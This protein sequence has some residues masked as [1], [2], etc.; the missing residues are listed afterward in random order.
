MTVT[1]DVTIPQAL[2]LQAMFEHWNRLAGL[3]SSREVAF[4]ADGDGNFRPRAQF[5]FSEE[6]PEL[7]D[8]LRNIAKRQPEDSGKDRFG[9]PMASFDFDSIAWRLGS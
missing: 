5:E 4:Y 9:S 1:M 3:G 2:A 8:E 6:I 7:D